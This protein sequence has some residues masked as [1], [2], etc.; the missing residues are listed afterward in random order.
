MS[1]VGHLPTF[2]KPRDWVCNAPVTR[3]SGPIAPERRV[4]TA[5]RTFIGFQVIQHVV[6]GYNYRLS[7]LTEVSIIL[8]DK[9]K[10][11]KSLNR[12]VEIT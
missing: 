5:D 4:C 9:L 12:L 2:R 3:H 10:R 8:I 7:G 6:A 1:G 11:G